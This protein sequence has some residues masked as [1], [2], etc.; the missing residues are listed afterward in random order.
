MTTFAK[1]FQLQQVDQSVFAATNR[2]SIGQAGPSPLLRASGL[3]L[4]QSATDAATI[5][6]RMVRLPPSANILAVKC[7]C[8]LTPLP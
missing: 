8:V 2:L 7:C 5:F 6:Y 4:T 3:A 1:S